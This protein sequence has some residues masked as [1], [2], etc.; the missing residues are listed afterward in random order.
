LTI[1]FLGI[2]LYYQTWANA[3]VSTVNANRIPKI[4]RDST[5]SVV[6]K[7][8]IED[9]NELPDKNKYQWINPCTIYKDDLFIIGG[10]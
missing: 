10:K 3:G 2:L 9:P 8:Q 6:G 7:Q 1:T 4:A 5:V